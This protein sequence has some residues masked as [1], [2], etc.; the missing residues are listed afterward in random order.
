M[1]FQE[2]AG[3]R[4]VRFRTSRENRKLG[5]GFSKTRNVRRVNGF[6]TRENPLG[7]MV[8]SGRRKGASESRAVFGNSMKVRDSMKETRDSAL[9]VAALLH[10]PRP[11]R[12][13]KDKEKG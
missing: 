8:G 4:V 13:Y 1:H 5:R 11:R 2:S 3:K 12:E 10:L 7:K 6:S 9:L